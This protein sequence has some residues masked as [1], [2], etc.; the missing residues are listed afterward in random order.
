MV[1]KELIEYF[2]KR[3]KTLSNK[4]RGRYYNIID[5]LNKVVN[6]I[7][8]PHLTEKDR[9]VLSLFYFNYTYGERDKIEKEVNKKLTEHRY[10]KIQKQ[11]AYYKKLQEKK[12][13]KGEEFKNIIKPGNVVEVDK[14]FMYVIMLNKDTFL[15]Q[16][17]YRKMDMP[18][19]I[20]KRRPNTVTEKLYKFIKRIVREEVKLLD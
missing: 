10:E 18:R 16:Y 15:G 19:N 9:E 14:G 7:N 13:K 12:K 3:S 6:N 5:D 11:Q 1:G 20:Y 8:I 2:F 4:G 17:V